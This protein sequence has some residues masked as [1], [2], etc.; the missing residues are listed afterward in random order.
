MMK[1]RRDTLK[2]SV[3][4]TE[5]HNFQCSRKREQERRGN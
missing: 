3:I 4:K 5:I 2:M 1:Q